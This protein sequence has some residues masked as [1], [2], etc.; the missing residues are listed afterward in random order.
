MAEKATLPEETVDESCWVW[1]SRPPLFYEPISDH[2]IE[3]KLARMKGAIEAGAD[4]NELDHEP[5]AR[6]NLGRPLDFAVNNG[7]AD[8]K[9]L[10]ENLPIIEL[11]LQH[12]ADPRLPGL[13]DTP[14]PLEYVRGMARYDEWRNPQFAHMKP[15]FRKAFIM[16]KEAAEK[17]DERDAAK[18]A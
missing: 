11:L 9:Y 17:L 7:L 3:V 13:L 10:K 15:F 2:P 18:R 6:R 5:D 4:V 14:S 8:F 16:M 1:K 12:G